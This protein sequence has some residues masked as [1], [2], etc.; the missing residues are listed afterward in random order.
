MALTITI[1]KDSEDFIARMVADGR[2][3]TAGEVINVGLRLVEAREKE[4]QAKIEFLR[5][6]IQKGFDSGPAIEINDINEFMENIKQ[7][8]LQR[9]AR[10]R[11]E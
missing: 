10:E 1:D 6:E 4:R 9:L 5:A 2:Y 7:R 11:A 3:G 8:G